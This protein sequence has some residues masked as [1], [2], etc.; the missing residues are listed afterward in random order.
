[1]VYIWPSPKQLRFALRV[2]LSSP[3]LDPTLPSILLAAV[4]EAHKHRISRCWR[5]HRWELNVISLISR[6]AS[7]SIPASCKVSSPLGHEGGSLPVMHCHV[8]LDCSTNLAAIA[9][10]RAMGST[11]FSLTQLLVLLGPRSWLSGSWLMPR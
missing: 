9:L 4:S 11:V 10:L 2:T 7:S 8:V 5:Q 1:M 3:R 6:C